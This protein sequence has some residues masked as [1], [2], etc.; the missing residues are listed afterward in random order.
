MREH[1]GKHYRDR[2][3]ECLTI[4]DVYLDADARRIMLR[5]AADYERMAEA[6]DQL[7]R[8]IAELAELAS[9]DSYDP[10]PIN[11]RK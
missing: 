8:D 6:A 3:E 7:D 2:A 5:V 9:Y 4:A 11:G 1:D 10:K